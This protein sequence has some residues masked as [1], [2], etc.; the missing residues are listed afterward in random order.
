[1]VM[2][3]VL[4]DTVTGMRDAGSDSARSPRYAGQRDDA[5]MRR[6]VLL[7]LMF[8][9]LVPATVDARVQDGVVTLT[10]TVS[11]HGARDVAMFL[12][13]CMPGVLGIRNEIRVIPT[14]SSTTWERCSG[15]ST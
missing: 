13:G 12:V 11:C 8:D 2:D 1:M 5:G 9:S 10:G 14:L 7:T 4:H 3:T 15:R 6:D